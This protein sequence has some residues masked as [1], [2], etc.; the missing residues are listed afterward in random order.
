MK[1]QQMLPTQLGSMGHCV[2]PGNVG[3]LVVTRGKAPKA[4]TI[5]KVTS[6]T[7]LFF[8]IKQCLMCN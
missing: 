8:V 6:A 3:A 1:W 5:L 4:P 7:K 2:V